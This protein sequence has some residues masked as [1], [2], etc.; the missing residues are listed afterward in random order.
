[1][2]RTRKSRV[3]DGSAGVTD[4]V[5]PAVAV[6]P[7]VLPCLVLG[8]AI[9]EDGHWQVG[10]WVEVSH[11][12]YT[13]WSA[14][15]VLISQARIDALW[16]AAGRILTPVGVA[17]HYEAATPT[18]VRVLQLTHFDPGSSVYRYHSAANTTSGVT[19]AFVRFGDNNFHCSLRQWDGDAD[20]GT[21]MALL[22][23]ADVVHCHM[24]YRCLLEELRV[25]RPRAQVVMTYH[26]SVEAER[27]A[28][29]DSEADA[30]MGA[31]VLGARPYH[32]QFGARWLPIPIPV[33][34]YAAM[35]KASKSGPLRVAHS[36]T[37]RAIKGTAV[38]LEA[39]KQLQYEGVAI[40]AVLIE[41]MPHADAL[42]VK[43]T[44]HA[45]FDSFWLG[46][47]GSGLEAAAMGQ[48]VIA[49]TKD[50]DYGRVG[51]PI[52]WTIADDLNSLVSVLRRLANDATFRSAEAERVGAYVRTYHDYIAVGTLYRDL[53]TEAT[54]GP[55]D[56][57]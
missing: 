44:C 41:G 57:R 51:L 14:R 9:T 21:V 29:V 47:Q 2:A 16:G 54:R 52:P 11:A 18:G 40:E 17:S 27:P 5:A 19:S 34:D 23:T 30:R 12:L 48:A 33:K 46:M 7:D 25:G 4:I 3:Q 49:G 38:F 50:A 6:V 24:D 53:L 26:G 36:P 15:G 35:A 28:I 45:T 8:E 42:R 20:R 10:Q 39:V 55:T 31:L 22:A 1:V 13:E 56:R 32:A 37:R 43:A